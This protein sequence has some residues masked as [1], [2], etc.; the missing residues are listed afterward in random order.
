M[1]NEQVI[2]L[3]PYAG[4]TNDIRIGRPLQYSLL[5]MLSSIVGYWGCS[6]FSCKRRACGVY[7]HR[8]MVSV[9]YSDIWA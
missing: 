7:L 1:D 9:W 2:T 6:L 4:M 8:G 3:A 5:H